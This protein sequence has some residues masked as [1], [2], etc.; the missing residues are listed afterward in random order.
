MKFPAVF[1]DRDG[2]L[3]EDT[4]LITHISQVKLFNYVGEV[5]A[6]M[7]GMGFKLFVVSNQTVVARGLLS[8]K[9]A[10]R[11]HY[12]ILRQILEQNPRAII[13]A[14][15]LCPYHPDAQVIQYRKN[16]DLRKPGIGMLVKAADKYEIDLN[17]SYVIGDRPTDIIM[18]NMAGCKTILV[19]TGQ[20]TAKLIKHGLPA[21]EINKFSKADSAASSLKHAMNIIKRDRIKKA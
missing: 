1:L 5:L 3:I 20:H 13:D 19:E 6:E 16:S 18:G 12:E 11:L 14:N 10:Y 7:R 17:H 21:S 15:Y 8:L 4:H 2:V 9:A